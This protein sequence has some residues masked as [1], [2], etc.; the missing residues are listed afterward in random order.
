[1]R[2][3]LL[4]ASP[5]PWARTLLVDARRRLTVV[6]HKCWSGLKSGNHP[7][8]HPMYVRDNNLMITLDETRYPTSIWPRHMC[9]GGTCTVYR[10]GF[11]YP[12]KLKVKI[13]WT[14]IHAGSRLKRDKELPTRLIDCGGAPSVVPRESST[15]RANGTQVDSWSLSSIT[16]K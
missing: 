7:G 12:T 3:A 13:G 8:R 14:V 16:M 4:S 11:C 6:S 5:L 15:R 2:V 1:M 10:W 9:G